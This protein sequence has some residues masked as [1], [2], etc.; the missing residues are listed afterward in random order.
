ME[1]NVNREI[2]NYHEGV[3]MGLST[4]QT[5]CASLAAVAA[6]GT[7]FGL[8]P[9]IGTELASV[10]CILAA[11]IPA[12]IGFMT[13]HGLPFEKLAFAW[14]RTMLIHNNGW[15][16]YKSVNFYAKFTPEALERNDNKRK[17]KIAQKGNDRV[18]QNEEN[19]TT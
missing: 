8:K 12:A 6:A 17:T 3:F 1:S 9:F 13:F 19:E 16:V 11:A 10:V 2:R 14:L 15:Y 5:V 7:N 4:R 18:N